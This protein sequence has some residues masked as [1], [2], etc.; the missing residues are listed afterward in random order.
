MFR[1]VEH[2]N[3]PREVGARDGHILQALALPAQHFFL[4]QRVQQLE[5]VRQPDLFGKPIVTDFT[6]A[7]D[8]LFARLTLEDAEY[9]LYNKI[10][11]HVRP[12]APV[13]RATREFMSGVRRKRA[14][15]PS[16]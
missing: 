15:Q 11:E 2:G 10:Y 16:R 4:V 7:K 1:I 14:G 8:P 13:P 3:A 12:Q 6:L 9:A 5:D